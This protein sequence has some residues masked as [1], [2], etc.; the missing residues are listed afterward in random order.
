MLA[1][2]PRVRAQESEPAKKSTEAI[3]D[4][5]NPRAAVLKGFTDRVNA[6]VDLQKKAEDGLPDLSG[7]EDPSKIEA[8]Q[9]AMAARMKL[10]RPDAKRGDLFADAEPIFRTAM[11]ED[12]RLR[13]NPDRRAALEEIPK[14]D[15]PRVN[16]AYPEKSPLATVPPLLLNQLPRLPEGLE[17][18]FM[19]DDL[20]LR[21]TKANLVA[22][23]I[24]ETVPTPKR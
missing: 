15:P 23:F 16:V 13:S 10:L 12:A 3:G 18:R 19:G 22:D 24:N 20:I 8:H 7:D 11:R 14:S 6:Y 1:E 5:V 2:A 21:D 17:Y 9:A 4:H